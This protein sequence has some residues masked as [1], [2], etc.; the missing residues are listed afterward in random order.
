M[1]LCKIRKNLRIIIDL[2]DVWFTSYSSDRGRAWGLAP[3]GDVVMFLVSS[4]DY[5]PGMIA[6]LGHTSEQEPQ[7]M[8]VSGSMW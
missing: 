8:Q 3:V 4:E 7:S 5:S 6:S 1:V 2:E